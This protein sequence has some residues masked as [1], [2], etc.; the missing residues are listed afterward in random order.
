MRWVS[1]RL[2]KSQDKKIEHLNNFVNISSYIISD[3]PILQPGLRHPVILNDAS[4]SSFHKWVGARCFVF[5]LG[6]HCLPRSVC[7]KTLVHQIFLNAISTMSEMTLSHIM[8]KPVYAICEQ[9]RC[10]SA[11]ASA[12]SDQHL[13]YSPPR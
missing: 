4:S 5:G 8:R 12:R 1:N 6:L 7:P 11:C 9:Q 2:S 10:R 13:F 3:K